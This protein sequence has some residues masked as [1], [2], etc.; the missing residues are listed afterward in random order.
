MAS[1]KI[2]IQADGTSQK[3]A[4]T[5][6]QLTDDEI[7]Q[8]W[9]IPSTMQQ[10]K[11]RSNSPLTH[12]VM[13]HKYTVLLKKFIR[14]LFFDHFTDSYS[15]EFL[16]YYLTRNQKRLYLLFS[17][18]NPGQQHIFIQIFTHMSL[19]LKDYHC[20][21]HDHVKV[22][23]EKTRENNYQSCV[24]VINAAPGTGK[25]FTVGVL[26]GAYA[27]KQSL[28]LV[29]TNNLKDYM[30]GFERTTSM[31][32]CQFMMKTLKLN[33]FAQMQLW[34]TSTKYTTFEQ[35]LMHLLL[36][37]SRCSF[38]E[39]ENLGLIVVDEYPTLSPWSVLYFYLI[40]KRNFIH[41]LLVGDNKQQGSIDKSQHH[42]LDNYMLMKDGLL[43]NE[44]DCIF[45]L[46]ENMRQ[47]ED[48]E[49]TKK[50]EQLMTIIFPSSNKG[51]TVP[52]TFQLKYMIFEMFEQHFYRPENHKALFMASYH[53]QIRDRTYRM[54]E[55]CR[56]NNI[57]HVLLGFTYDA[58][59]Q[60]NNL[61]LQ[62][63]LGYLNAR[64]YKATKALYCKCANDNNH[65]LD[66]NKY[67]MN[68]YGTSK[69]WITRHCTYTYNNM[70]DF[71]DYTQ[72][73]E[74]FGKT[75]FEDDCKFA[76][77]LLM[78]PNNLYLMNF[79]SGIKKYVRFLGVYNRFMITEPTPEI[80]PVCKNDKNV[81]V[82][83]SNR[84]IKPQYDNIADKCKKFD[85]HKNKIDLICDSEFIQTRKLPRFLIM[86]EVANGKKHII[87]RKRIND[88]FIHADLMKWLQTQSIGILTNNKI[89]QFPL[90]TNTL[91]YYAAQ[92]LTLDVDVLDLNIDCTTLN[93][94]Y[95]GFTRIRKS[96][97]LNSLVTDE[98]ISLVIT[99]YFNSRFVYRLSEENRQKIGTEIKNKT[100]DEII[101]V[102]MKYNML[103]H[104][105]YKETT[106]GSMFN[107]K[108]LHNS[109]FP[110]GDYI[111]LYMLKQI[112]NTVKEDCNNTDEI[113]DK[114]KL[115]KFAQFLNNNQNFQ[116]VNKFIRDLSVEDVKHK[117]KTTVNDV[118][119][120]LYTFMIENIITNI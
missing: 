86:E 16:F 49:Y 96:E 104:S 6:T 13:N 39:F 60:E 93:S 48:A 79:P 18:L 70:I 81:Y 14:Q 103:S 69:S 17:A 2:I 111:G 85:E 51:I 95:V 110:R 67:N 64:F 40:C 119:K 74:R 19:M 4:T 21:E 24:H 56:Q 106:N 102:C 7:D 80:I 5:A 118:S 42:D 20:Y 41:L 47:R 27:A 35:Q 76:L 45:T 92:G 97:Q 100:Y 101:R 8:L 82:A 62:K 105:R 90:M 91:T 12:L 109:I 115:I 54:V 117:H 88:T 61:L 59:E 73:I 94:L 53:R 26:M 34:K 55:T 98:L 9:I 63:P 32:T 75:D 29:Y 43:K 77:F 108:L 114:T 38:K 116:L 66:T 57:P 78:I 3:I 113:C 52:M 22:L 71:C 99:K 30:D 1:S 107:K 120:Q 36:M 37:V 112:T 33:Y 89:Y 44:K 72:D 46:N 10:I 50:V 31:T 25:S 11:Q 23:A 65:E 15:K 58:L 84:L 28:Y 83:S 68:I 87:E